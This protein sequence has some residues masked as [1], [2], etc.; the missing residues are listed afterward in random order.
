MSKRLV[1][2]EGKGESGF[3]LD[4]FPRTIRQA[5]SIFVQGREYEH[6]KKKNAFLSIHSLFFNLNDD[7]LNYL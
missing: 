4:G 5:V 6:E 7:T 1:S 3:I 2:G